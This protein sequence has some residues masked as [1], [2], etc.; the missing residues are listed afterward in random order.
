MGANDWNCRGSGKC[1]LPGLDPWIQ[2]KQ[3]FGHIA[4]PVPKTS[5]PPLGL[6]FVFAPQDGDGIPFMEGQLIVVLGFVVPQ[7][8]HNAFVHD[9]QLLLYSWDQRGI[10][11]SAEGDSRDKGDET[12]ITNQP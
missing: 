7:S 12:S 9:P 11:V 10:Q 3:V 6:V 8:I 4:L 2:P 1:S 5:P